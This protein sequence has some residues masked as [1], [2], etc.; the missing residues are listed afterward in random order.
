MQAVF[1]LPMPADRGVKARSR[2]RAGIHAGHEIPA[3]LRKKHAVGRTDFPVGAEQYL[4][5]G[6]VQTLTQILGITKIEPEPAGLTA[7]PL[8]SV[9]T[10]AGRSDDDAA[11]QARRASSMSGWLALT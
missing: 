3:F 9:M 8:F 5:V 11:K 10:W 7:T 2:D 1:H 6:Y 4:A